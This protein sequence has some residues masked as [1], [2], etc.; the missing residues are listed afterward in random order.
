MGEH[1]KVLIWSR[2][3]GV[4]NGIVNSRPVLALIWFQ[5]VIILDLLVVMRMF[6]KS[7]EIRVYAER[8]LLA[9]RIQIN[10]SDKKMV[11]TIMVDQQC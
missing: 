5:V 10:E 1:E 9:I 7:R 11:D 6:G 3:G 2:Y 8:K 4:W